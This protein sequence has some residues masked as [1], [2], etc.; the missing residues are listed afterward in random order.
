MASNVDN[1]TGKTTEAF[2]KLNGRDIDSRALSV[3]LRREGAR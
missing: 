3:S 1:L 2:A